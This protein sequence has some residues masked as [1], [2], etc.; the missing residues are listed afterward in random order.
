[1]PQFRFLPAVIITA[2]VIMMG[3][4]VRRE[5]FSAE[6]LWYP[7]AALPDSGAV[8]WWSGIYIG[9]EKTPFH[10]F[11]KINFVPYTKVSEFADYLK[12]GN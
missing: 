8:E 11:G 9:G 3:L 5:Y 7:G 4:L 1:M 12:D 2:W 6:P 10:Y